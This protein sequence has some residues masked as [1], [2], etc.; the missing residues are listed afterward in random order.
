M[1]YVGGLWLLWDED[2]IKLTIHGNTLQEIHTIVEVRGIPPL[3]LSFIYGKPD[4]V[5]RKCLWK[6]LISLAPLVD[7]P[8]MMCGDFNDI[9]SPDEKWGLKPPSP[10]RIH[11]FRSCLDSCGLIDLGYTGQKFTWFNKRDNSNVGFQRLDRFVGNVEFL[12]YFPYAVINH[13]P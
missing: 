1:G 12:N 5:V 3:F 6:N 10:S 9:L 7:F 13:F 8:W 11:D 4:R 2:R